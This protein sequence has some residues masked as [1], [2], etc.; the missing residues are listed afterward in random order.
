MGSPTR[1][2]APYCEEGV[3]RG[4]FDSSENLSYW[5]GLVLIFNTLTACTL[6]GSISMTAAELETLFANDAVAVI[7]AASDAAEAHMAV[8]VLKISTNPGQ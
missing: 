4:R 3:Q 2:L 5:P 7:N 6:S 8:K 1:P